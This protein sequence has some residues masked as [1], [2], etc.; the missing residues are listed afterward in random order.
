[1]ANAP[2]GWYADPAGDTTKLRYWDGTCWTD[3]LVDASQPAA[4]SAQTT[5]APVFY[6]QPP[7]LTN[8]HEDGLRLAAFIFCIV[9]MVVVAWISIPLAWMIPM[10]VRCWRI[11]KRTRPNTMAFGVCMLI[12][13]SLIAG[14]LLLIAEKDT[15]NT[16]PPIDTQSHMAP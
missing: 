1:M 10:S 2:A 15:L 6:P 14:I 12:F 4:S 16:R 9:S 7:A 11:Y 13:M 5:S 8:S 3:S